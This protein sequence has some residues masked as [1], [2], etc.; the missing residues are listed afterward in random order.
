MDLRI[1]TVYGRK[2]R[3]CKEKEALVQSRWVLSSWKTR[4]IGPVSEAE[5]WNVKILKLE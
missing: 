1:Q 4:M 5:L 3:V 2:L